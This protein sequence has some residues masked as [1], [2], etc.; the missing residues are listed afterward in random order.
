MG[1]QDAEWIA[2]L[3]MEN[4]EY[5]RLKARHQ[6]FDRKLQVLSSKR[7]LTDEEKV[8][9]VRM[10]KEKLFLK[11]RIAAIER[12]HAPAVES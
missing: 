8:E 1:A 9:E 12:E 2:R 4:D 7:L 10:K 6:E 3:E 5:R 11:D